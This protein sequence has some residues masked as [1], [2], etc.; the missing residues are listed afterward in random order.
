MSNETPS[1]LNGTE[2]TGGSS[3]APAPTPETAISS[4]EAAAPPAPIETEAG[5]EKAVLLMRVLNMGA[6]IALMTV[7][8]SL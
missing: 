6:A 2:N 1:W 4:S 5:V 8:V 7:S 3:P